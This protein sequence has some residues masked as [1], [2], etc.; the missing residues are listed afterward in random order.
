M[1]IPRYHSS[2]RTSFFGCRFYGMALDQDHP[3]VALS[4]LI[5]REK[6]SQPLIKAYKGKGMVGR[7]R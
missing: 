2:R 3:L 7:P 4:K 5:D 1:R 6:L